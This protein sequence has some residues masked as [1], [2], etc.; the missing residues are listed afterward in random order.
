MLDLH[1]YFNLTSDQREQRRKDRQ[2]QEWAKTIK[3]GWVPSLS[4]LGATIKK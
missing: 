1:G 4:E 3:P 2:F